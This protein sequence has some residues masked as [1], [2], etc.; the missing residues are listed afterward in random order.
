MAR[1]RIS[2]R[3]LEDVLLAQKEA[4]R[5]VGEALKSE[6]RGGRTLRDRSKIKRPRNCYAEA[7]LRE[8]NNDHSYERNAL[9]RAKLLKQARDALIH[10][11]NNAPEMFDGLE[12][13]VKETLGDDFVEHSV[14]DS[15]SE[16]DIKGG[17]ESESEDDS[18]SEG[19]DSESDS[20]SEEDEEE[21]DSEGS[22]SDSEDSDA[23][24]SEEDDSEDDSESEEEKPP[25]TKRPPK[26]RVISDDD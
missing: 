11:W 3:E 16:S 15:E 23:E 20:E 6:I 18:D 26:K 19:S 1:A 4:S 24:G 2:Q 13:E 21:D 7:L 17:S 9:K 8:A 25:M 22:D 12:D 5:I 10:A 14:S